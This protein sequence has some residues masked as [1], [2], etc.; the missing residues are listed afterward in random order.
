[1]NNEA[2]YEALLAGLK[3]A[4]DLSTTNLEVYSDSQLVINQVEGS[5]EAKD[6]RMVGYLRLVKQTMS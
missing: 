3:V 2:E 1:M 6:P 5:F 4:L